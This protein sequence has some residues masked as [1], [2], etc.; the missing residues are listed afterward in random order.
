M[1]ERQRITKGRQ[2]ETLERQIDL[3]VYDL[4]SLSAQE[5]AEIEKSKS[6]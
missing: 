4:Y 2:T 6:K 5:I 3:L 1:K